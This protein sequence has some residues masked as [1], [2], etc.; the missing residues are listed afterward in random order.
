MIDVAKKEDSRSKV[1]DFFTKKLIS[2]PMFIVSGDQQRGF[3]CTLSFNIN[4]SGEQLTVETHD[5]MPTKAKSRE[6]AAG[7]ALGAFISIPC[8]PLI[9]VDTE[10]YVM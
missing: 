6:I 1:N 3:V 2:K 5:R 7:K 9:I 10:I 8:A 4:E